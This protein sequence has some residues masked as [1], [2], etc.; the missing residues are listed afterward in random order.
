MAMGGE[1][2]A[3]ERRMA[4]EAGVGPRLI[5]PIPLSEAKT[6]GRE[7]MKWRHKMSGVIVSARRDAGV[8]GQSPIEHRACV[9]SG[10]G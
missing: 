1:A 8:A 4:T 2:Q 6:A 5:A 3:R 9:T 10:S 7:G